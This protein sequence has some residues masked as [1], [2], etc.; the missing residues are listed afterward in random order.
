M[1]EQ[2][3]WRE[4][5]LALLKRCAERG[6]LPAVDYAAAVA[7]EAEVAAYPGPKALEAG[8]HYCPGLNLWIDKAA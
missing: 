7:R 1:T 6:L 2:E 8:L 4:E 5:A 3:H